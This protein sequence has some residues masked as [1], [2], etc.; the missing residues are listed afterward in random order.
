MTDLDPVY[1]MNPYLLDYYKLMNRFVDD[2][3]M[4]RKLKQTYPTTYKDLFYQEPIG[5]KDIPKYSNPIGPEIDRQY[6]N[7]YSQPIGPEYIRPEPHE[8][9]ANYGYYSKPI[10]PE[11]NEISQQAAAW[12]SSLPGLLIKFGIPGLIGGGLVYGGYKTYQ[13]WTNK[14]K[15]VRVDAGVNKEPEEHEFKTGIEGKYNPPV[16]YMNP[17]EFDTSAKIRKL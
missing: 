11:F 13:W 17:D 14:K 12:G 15:K 3:E 4:N 1:F 9:N 10:G 5:P 16:V 6:E 2:D 8:P 7:Y